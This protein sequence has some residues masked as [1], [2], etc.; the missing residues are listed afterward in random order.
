LPKAI[1][2]RHSP[3]VIPSIANSSNAANHQSNGAIFQSSILNKSSTI[4]RQSSMDTDI[5][6]GLTD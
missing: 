1:L 5:A 3:I 4:I 6:R 2:A